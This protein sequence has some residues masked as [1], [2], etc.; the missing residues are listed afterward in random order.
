MQKRLSEIRTYEAKPIEDMQDLTKDT[1]N[2]VNR[3][4]SIERDVMK[5]LNIIRVFQFSSK[6]NFTAHQSIFKNLTKLDDPDGKSTEVSHKADKLIKRSARKVAESARQR[7]S[8]EIREEIG[9]FMNELVALEFKEAAGAKPR[10]EDLPGEDD[11]LGFSKLS[12][13]PHI[14]LP[15][16]RKTTGNK[17]ESIQEQITRD[18]F[19]SESIL[20]TR[21]GEL[22]KAP[23]KP[24]G[25]A[26]TCKCLSEYY[27]QRSSCFLLRFI[28]I[29]PQSQTSPLESRQ[30][31]Q[32]FRFFLIAI[33][34]LNKKPKCKGK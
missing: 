34:S 13:S 11:F 5:L 2:L 25:Q 10:H 16:K 8:A 24:D 28:S 6:L 22:P 7:K 33:L 29:A 19:Q 31:L 21:M 20:T 18:F 1:Q 30:N 32:I 15:D 9:E 12:S 4:V 27:E 23:S 26:K 17:I 3:E 14:L